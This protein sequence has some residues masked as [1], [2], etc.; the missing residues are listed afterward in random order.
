MITRSA[1]SFRSKK[2]AKSDGRVS[3]SDAESLGEIDVEAGL[4]T[5]PSHS[6][7]ITALKRAQTAG[8]FGSGSGRGRNTSQRD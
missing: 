2:R 3:D 5:H 6:A 8:S 7:S 4:R 1:S